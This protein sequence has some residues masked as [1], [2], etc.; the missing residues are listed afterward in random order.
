MLS[1]IIHTQWSYHHVYCSDCLVRRKTFFWTIECCFASPTAHIYLSF[2]SC[3]FVWD[4]G[5]R[6]FWSS[7]RRRI[8]PRFPRHET[9][10]SLP[11]AILLLFIYFSCYYKRFA[12]D[13]AFVCTLVGNRIDGHHC[14]THSESPNG[15][16]LRSRTTASIKNV[17]LGC[18]CRRSK[19]LAILHTRVFAGDYPLAHSHTHKQIYNMYTFIG[20]SDEEL[21]EREGKSKM[22]RITLAW[23]VPCD[24]VFVIV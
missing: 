18:Y 13:C 6:I 23:M 17:W 16:R 8:R 15:G 11:S 24:D 7:N 9:P 5:S 2:C 3:V 12:N 10:S 14:W 19:E 4:W 21:R 22:E 1:A 20:L